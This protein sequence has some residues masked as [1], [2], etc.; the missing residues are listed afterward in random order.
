MIYPIYLYGHPV[1]RKKAKE[2]DP[3]KI[4]PKPLINDMFQTMYNAL[5]V[6]LAGPQ[7]GKS[8]RLY[9]IDANPMAEAHPELEGFKRAFI[10]PEI[11]E[12]SEETTGFEEGCLSIPGIFEQV[13]RYKTLTMRYLDENMEEKTENF[14]GIQAVVVQHEY[15]HLSGVLFTD[16]IAPLK[17]RL[18]KSRLAAIAK[19]KTKTDYKTVIR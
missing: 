18:L 3:C 6:G 1:L 11:I 10:N 16:K 17:K 13:K 5:G 15:D 7:I 9:V 2:I 19:G 14:V 8:L 12:H 4:D